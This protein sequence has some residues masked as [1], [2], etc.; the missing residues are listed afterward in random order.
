MESTDT[1]HQR[2]TGLSFSVPFLL[3][4]RIT[5]CHVVESKDKVSFFTSITRECM[6]VWV[7]EEEQ[8]A[9]KPPS[10][11]FIHKIIQILG[12]SLFLSLYSV[13]SSRFDHQVSFSIEFYLQ[14]RLLSVFLLFDSNCKFS[15]DRYFRFDYKRRFFSS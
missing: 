7:S 8:R 13:S 9:K 11:H 4:A 15:F 10:T 3:R 12:S 6:Y 2:I 14:F 5:M 1:V